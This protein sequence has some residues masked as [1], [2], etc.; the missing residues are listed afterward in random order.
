MT[1]SSGLSYGAIRAYAE[2]IGKAHN[3][4]SGSGCADVHTLVRL[5]GGRVEVSAWGSDESLH[6]DDEDSF[7]IYL[8]P[9]TSSRRDRFTMAHEL[10]HYFL[11]YL[12]PSKRGVAS[13]NRGSRNRAETE[14][15]V[16]ASSLLMP[17][18]EF[19][20]GHAELYPD[21]HALARRFDVSPAAAEVR[22]QV[23]GL[24]T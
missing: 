12:Y 17:A 10:G 8:P 7:T 2:R 19:E 18:A 6:V 9:S 14:A 22:C 16:F 23:L 4:Y 3:I 20:R 11:H 1:A 5:L 21:M 15:N 13:F 24:R